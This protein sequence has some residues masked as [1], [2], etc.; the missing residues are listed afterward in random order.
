MFLFLLQRGASGCG[1][2]DPSLMNTRALTGVGPEVQDSLPKLKDLTF[3]KKQLEYLQ[4]PVEDEV[5]SGVGQD[6]SLLS[7]PFLK[8][9]LAGYVVARL[10][11]SAVLGSA[12]GTC[13]GIYTAQTY[14]VPNVEKTL[15]NYIRS[16]RK[17]PD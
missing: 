6:G 11:A 7:S 5:N 16:L 4:Q 10:R 9:S 2:V 17:E 1:I 3:L 13:T 8:G 14:A 15:K 12:V